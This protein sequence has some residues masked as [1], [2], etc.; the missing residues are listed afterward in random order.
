MCEG[1]TTTGGGVTAEV[2]AEAE[3]EQEGQPGRAGRPAQTVTVVTVEEIIQRAKAKL[4]LPK[5][6]IGSAPC[7]D[8]ECEGTVGVPTWFWLEDDQWKTQTDTATAGSKSVKIKAT[9]S[10][11]TWSL[12]DGQS[13]SCSGP[14]TPFDSSTGYGP[15]PDCGIEQGYQ[16]AGTYTLTATITY[17]IAITGATEETD[18]ITTSSSEEVTV[19]EA[20]A[21]V[22]QSDR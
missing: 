1:A 21:I 16:S 13:V 19:G 20:Q 7:T 10:K 6:K 15:S 18:T 14:G 4:D 11:T 2:A 5:P 22:G 17:D 12:G 3:G 9:P 8:D